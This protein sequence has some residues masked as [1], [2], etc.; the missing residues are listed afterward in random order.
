MAPFMFGIHCKAHRTNL[1]VRA[2]SNLHVVAKIEALC[3]AMFPYFSHSPKRHLQFQKL[4]ELVETE[5]RHM[6]RNVKTRWLSLLDP[7]KRVMGEYQ[8]LVVTILC[9]D[10]AVMTPRLTTKGDCT[11]QLRFVV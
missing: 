6:L 9:E 11:P 1:A 7:L 4:A 10:S 2:L 3:Q 8:T 5:G